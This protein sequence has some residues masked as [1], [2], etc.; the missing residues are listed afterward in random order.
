[1]KKTGTITF[2]WANNYGAVLQSYALQQFLVKSGYDTEIINYIPLR[3]KLIQII[4]DIKN[5][6]SGEL[7]KRRNIEK[8]RKRELLLSKKKY[9]S[10][11]SI[12][13]RQ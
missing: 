13:I 9:S 2:H 8:F 10:N 7:E 5:G 6:K 1:M 4:T 11:V 12:I 3:V